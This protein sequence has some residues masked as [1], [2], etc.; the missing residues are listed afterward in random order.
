MLERTRV[1]L[2]ASDVLDDPMLWEMESL[3]PIERNVLLERHLVSSDLIGQRDGTVPRGAAL[4]LAEHDTLGLM[5]NEEDHLRLQTLLGGLQL[6]R[7]ESR[8]AAR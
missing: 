2:A 3:D 5:I 8:G 7:L 6:D 1:A 4:A